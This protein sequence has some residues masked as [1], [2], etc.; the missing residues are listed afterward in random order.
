MG[1]FLLPD[2]PMS[3]GLVGWRRTSCLGIDCIARPCTAHISSSWCRALEPRDLRAPDSSPCYQ[4]HQRSQHIHA[5]LPL[6]LEQQS[7]RISWS[8]KWPKNRRI[9]TGE[10]VRICW[11]KPNFG[12]KTIWV[13]KTKP[14]RNNEYASD[15]EPG[16][17]RQERE[18]N[19]KVVDIT[20]TYPNSLYLD[21]DIIGT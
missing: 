12:S 18:A 21:S 20:S 16:E 1:G 3:R 10:Q 17:K 9:K 6:A 7:L 11:I 4:L 8:E 13:F 2:L 5:Q 15:S 14:K 19:L